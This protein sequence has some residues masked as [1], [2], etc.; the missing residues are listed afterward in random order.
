MG[1][2][3]KTLLCFCHWGRINKVLPDG[4]ISY[5]GCTTDHVIAK[6]G[7]K[8]D[9]F[10]N[11]VFDRLGIDPSNKMLYFTVKFDRSELIQLRDQQEKSSEPRNL[12]NDCGQQWDTA[13]TKVA[14]KSRK[15]FRKQT[16]ELSESDD[17]SI[18]VETE[19]AE[20]ENGNSPPAGLSNTTKTPIETFVPLYNSA[21]TTSDGLSNTNKIK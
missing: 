17:T 15:R 20:I 12:E 1:I 11:A 13:M 9:D 3:E 14:C 18:S 7:I 6:M 21:Y 16:V 19:D 5:K 4:L 8:Y 2:E 10:V